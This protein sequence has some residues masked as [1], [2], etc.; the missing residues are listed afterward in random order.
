M[1]K[2]YALYRDGLLL[3]RTKTWVKA[4]KVM[5]DC[6]NT[7]KVFEIKVEEHITPWTFAKSGGRFGQTTELA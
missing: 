3:I 6:I 7:G 5:K 2:H 1:K 4:N